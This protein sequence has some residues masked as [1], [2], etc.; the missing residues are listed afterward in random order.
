MADEP[1]GAATLA[2]V[3]TG[4]AGLDEITFGGLPR[5]RVSLVCGGPGA[6]KS[7]L[8]LQFLVSGATQFGEPGV[9]VSF[10]ETEGEI[11]ENSVSLGWELPALTARGLLRVEQVRVDRAELAVTGEYDLEALLIR[12]GHTVAAIGA[13]RVVLDSVEV[14][15]A[16][17]ADELLLRSELRR[18]FG[19]LKEIGVTG[20]VT[21]ER[22]AGELTRYGLE[23]YV[24]DCVILL[25]QRVRDE[26]ATRRVR[27]VKYRGSPH[28]SSE[29]PFLIDAGGLSVSPPRRRLMLEN[30]T[31]SER[32]TSGVQR[33][34]EMLGGG[35][36]RAAAVLVSGGPGCGKTSL[37]AALV[38]A[39]CESGER[40][41]YVAMEES[42]SQVV[43]N[44]RS[45]GIDLE[46]FTRD[47]T[48]RFIARRASEAGLEE[49][50]V[51]IEKSVVAF[52]PTT[53]VLDPVSAF[54][55]AP[56]VDS[57]LARLIDFVRGRGITVFLTSLRRVDESIGSSTSSAVDTWL[58]LSNHEL[59]GERNR[60][61]TVLKSR[62][63]EH[64]NQL[65]EFVLS[66]DGV[67]IVDAFAGEGGLLM[68]SARL[69]AQ[70]L[71]QAA[72]TKREQAV[73][74]SWRRLHARRAAV[75][76]QIAALEAELEVEMAAAGIDIEQQ[77]QSEAQRRRDEH[78]RGSAR[79]HERSAD[80]ESE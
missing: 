75:A 64:S 30:E 68:G 45:I 25:D 18:L 5:G 61:I 43:R 26:I 50:L 66:S 40:C 19:W 51:A 6:G 72:S 74:T 27:I 80:A 53:V 13:K 54:G 60:A 38:R 28:R 56:E 31:S 67:E 17:L 9:F 11:A 46:P 35:Y 12:V 2:K 42:P 24:S 79:A 8:A 65:R 37:A 20:V 23:E 48:L 47:D 52:A 58:Q 32:V 1:L 69:E 76:A 78:T 14:L 10:Q 7:V 57:F 33:L 49:H 15:F 16:E 70:T 39:A 62:G 63:S 44:M 21:A 22:G 71:E 73:D 34:D 3:P 55:R 77:Q 29:Y 4:I 36:F 41:L 59:A